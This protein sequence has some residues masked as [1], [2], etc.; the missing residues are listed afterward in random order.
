MSRYVDPLGEELAPFTMPDQLLGVG[1]CGWPVK[2]FSESLS[3]Q[4]SRSSM[5]AIG[6]S[7]YVV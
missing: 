3:D 1:D 2:I 5:I 6:P 4:R 7:V